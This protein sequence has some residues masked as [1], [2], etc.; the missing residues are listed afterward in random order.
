MQTGKWF[1]LQWIK[2]CE[3]Y[4]LNPLKQTNMIMVATVNLFPTRHPYS[5]ITQESKLRKAMP[6]I[7]YRKYLEIKKK[8]KI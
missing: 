8:K 5:T 7:K 2:G 3:W 1:V 4:L 6:K